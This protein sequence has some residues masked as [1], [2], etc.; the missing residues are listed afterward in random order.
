M[1][2]C[3]EQ[4]VRLFPS[5]SLEQVHGALAFYLHHRA[6]CDAY[7]AEQRSR[8]PEFEQASAERNR[9]LRERIRERTESGGEHG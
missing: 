7:M 3:A 8:W 5:L 9:E 2:T 4:I 6:M 1:R